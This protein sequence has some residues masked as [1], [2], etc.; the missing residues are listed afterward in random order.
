MQNALL[1]AAEMSI[2]PWYYAVFAKT[3]LADSFEFN[4]KPDYYQ[5]PKH[6]IFHA[7]NSLNGLE[8]GHMGIVLYN[9]NIVKNQ[10]EFGI[11]Y[12]MSAPH[13]VVPELSANASFNSTPYQTWRTAFREAAKLAQFCDEQANIENEYR[14]QVWLTKAKGLYSEWCLQGARDGYEFYQTNKRMPA[15]L[16]QAFDWTWL[17]SYFESIYNDIIDPNLTVLVHRQE[18]WQPLEHL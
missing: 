18:S 3:E 4:F 16:K 6:Y 11:D 13:V 15:N 1:R 10:K 7:R 12:T 17:Q 2:T 14:L 5:L 9:C 8:Y